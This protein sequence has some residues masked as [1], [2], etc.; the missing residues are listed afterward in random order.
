M[1]EQVYWQSWNRV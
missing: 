1:S